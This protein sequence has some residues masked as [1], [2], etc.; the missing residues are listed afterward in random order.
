MSNVHQD[1]LLE[2]LPELEKLS[3]AR[4]SINIFDVTGM[5]QQEIRHS[6]V[7]GFFLDPSGEHGLADRFLKRLLQTTVKSLPI[8]SNASLQAPS[9]LRIMLDD[10]ADAIV[11][12]EWLHI[13]LIIVS[14]SNKTVF[15]IENKVGAKEGEN[16]LTKYREKISEHPKFEGY[17][18]IY[19]FLTPDGDEGSDAEWGQITYDDILDNLSACHKE[20]EATITDEAKLLLDHYAQLIRRNVLME[21]KVLVEACREIYNRHRNAINLIMKYGAP[22]V[23]NNFI[24]AVRKFSEEHTDLLECSIRSNRAFF[25]PEKIQKNI[26]DF[27]INWWEQKKPFGLWFSSG[28]DEK[29]QTLKIG[30]IIEIGPFGNSHLDRLALVTKVLDAVSAKQRKTFNTYTRVITKYDDLDPDAPSEAIYEKMEELY[31]ATLPDLG[32][33]IDAVCDFFKEN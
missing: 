16:Q 33:S 4:S 10:Y 26:P 30:I 23:G 3:Q 22:S 1:E 31:L 32:K 5:R 18:K 25:S 7:L 20:I 15:V 28:F 6:N 19:A 14:E 9:A 11:Y 27:N 12:R 21:D 29:K 2:L 24:D 13:D 8:N 17:Q